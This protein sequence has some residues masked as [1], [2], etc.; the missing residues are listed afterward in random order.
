[1]VLVFRQSFENRII[2]KNETRIKGNKKHVKKIQNHV[3]SS[4]KSI[5]G[6]GVGGG[7]GSGGGVLGGEES[8]ESPNSGSSHNSVLARR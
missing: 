2:C 6:G 7:V 5:T 8:G 1:M 4:I 3:I